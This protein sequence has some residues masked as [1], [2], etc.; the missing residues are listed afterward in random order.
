MCLDNLLSLNPRPV[1]G[2][3]NAITREKAESK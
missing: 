1:Q 3:K 2:Y